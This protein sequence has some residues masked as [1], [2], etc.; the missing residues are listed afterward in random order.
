M[1]CDLGH[2]APISAIAL[3][4]VIMTSDVEWCHATSSAK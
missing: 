2:D 4:I 1:S 3:A